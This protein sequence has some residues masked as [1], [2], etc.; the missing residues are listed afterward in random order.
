MSSAT[1]MYT[2]TGVLCNMYIRTTFFIVLCLYVPCSCNGHRVLDITVRS[3]TTRIVYCSIHESYCSTVVLQYKRNPFR[4]N[5]TNKHQVKRVT[6]VVIH[7]F[8]V[9]VI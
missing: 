7:S 4:E 9:A 5:N 1:S 8:F 2:R 6:T 3:T